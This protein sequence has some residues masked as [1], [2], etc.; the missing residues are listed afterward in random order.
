MR[1]WGCGIAE[2]DID[3]HG[4]FRGSELSRESEPNAIVHSLLPDWLRD[5]RLREKSDTIIDSSNLANLA[6]DADEPGR[7]WRSAPEQIEILSGSMWASRPCHE[8]QS[9]LQH[10]IVRVLG[11]AEPVEE[12]LE[13][14]ADEK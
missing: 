10:E 3:L 6:E 5:D 11:G 4:D 14:V 13:N 9:P 7:V 8:Q 2:P 12:P 1:L